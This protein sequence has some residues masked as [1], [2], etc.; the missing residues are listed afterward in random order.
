MWQSFIGRFFTRLASIPL[1][2]IMMTALVTT[3]IPILAEK[4]FWYM[5]HA[6]RTDFAMSMLLVFILIYG[7]GKISFDYWIQAKKPKL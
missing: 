3:K 1:L 4:G 5:A 6:A 7:A 2:I